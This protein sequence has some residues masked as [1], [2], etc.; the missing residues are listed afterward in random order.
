MAQPV[1]AGL[2]LDGSFGLTLTIL[3]LVGPGTVCV[4]PVTVCVGPVTVWVEPGVVTVVVTV[5][6]EPGVVTIVVTVWVEPVVVSVVVVPVD[7]VS[8][9]V[10]PVDVAQA[11]PAT[12][13]SVVETQTPAPISTAAATIAT[14][15]VRLV[16][17]G[18]FT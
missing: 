9:H 14:N 6:V 12:A 1:F 3:I 17:R 13:G 2:G 16:K 10:V 5:W 15:Q 8:V 7:V 4:G 18:R 11:V